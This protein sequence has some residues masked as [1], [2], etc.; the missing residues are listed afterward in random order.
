MLKIADRDLKQLSTP[1]KAL[2]IFSFFAILIF[3]VCNQTDTE[4]VA[5]DPAVEIVVPEGNG[6]PVLI[7]GVFQKGE[8]DDA[9]QVQVSDIVKLYFKKFK[10]HL[11]IAME[12]NDVIAIVTNLFFAPDDSTIYQLHVSAQL[13]EITLK[14]GAPDEEDMDYVW[15]RTEG[16]YSNEIR[17][18]VKKQQYLI[19]SAGVNEGEAFERSKF[20]SDG[21]EFQILQSKFGVDHLKFRAETIWAPNYNKPTV[22]PPGTTRKNLDSWTTLIL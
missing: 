12:C 8:W 11:F 21:L 15:G 18:D 19:D 3:S 13:G 14:P 7:D 1:A 17:W 5:T 6:M 2:F 16:W 20:P 22:F 9:L 10:G 4:S